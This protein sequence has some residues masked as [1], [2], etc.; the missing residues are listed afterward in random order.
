[1]RR[2]WLSG[3]AGS[4][5]EGLSVGVNERA[6]CG[7]TAFGRHGRDVVAL[8]EQHER[9]LQAQLGAPLRERHTQ[10]VAEQTAQ[11]ALADTDPAADLLQRQGLGHVVGDQ[12]ARVPQPA[13]G[14]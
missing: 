6:W 12:R 1:M 13:I 7:P 9:M 14:W 5:S 4:V 2:D 10:L 8:G 11:R 3:L